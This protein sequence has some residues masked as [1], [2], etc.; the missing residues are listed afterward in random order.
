MQEENFGAIK[1]DEQTE[2]PVPEEHHPLLKEIQ[3]YTT[4]LEQTRR[5]IGRLS[6]IVHNLTHHA[7]ETEEAVREKRNKLT[8]EL[9]G[10]SKGKW[11]IDFEE[12][13]VA[14]VSPGM[15]RPV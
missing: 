1:I 14:K 9:M 2:I 11:V 3:K 15:P 5:E 10:L 6:Q 12:K 8:E 13:T 7:N 4:E